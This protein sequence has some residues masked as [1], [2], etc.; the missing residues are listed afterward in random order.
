MKK[1]EISLIKERFNSLKKGEVVD[2]TQLTPDCSLRRYFR[3]RHS[4][5]AS[6]GSPDG[7]DT[8]DTDGLK[9]MCS[10]EATVIAVLYDSVVGAE[11][12]G[13]L[14]IRSDDAFVNV[15]E[16]FRANGLNVPEILAEFRDDSLYFIEDFGDTI[17][18][19][20]LLQQGSSPRSIAK[21]DGGE[22]TAE[23]CLSDSEVYQL[24]CRAIDQ[25]VTLQSIAP[26]G[27]CVAFD[28]LFTAE[29]YC[30]EMQ[31]VIDYSLA[32]IEVSQS[33]V[34]QMKEGFLKL[35]KRLVRHPIVLT[36]RDY[37]PWNLLVLNGKKVGIIDFQDALQGSV[38]YDVV[39]LLNDRSADVL[40]GR[41]R[42]YRLWNY[43]KTA[44]DFDRNGFAEL[45]YAESL[46]QR[47][48]KVVGLFHKIA[49]LRGLKQYLGWVPGTLYRIGRTLAFLG[50]DGI[51]KGE[52]DSSVPL[53]YRALRYELSLHFPEVVEG[54][55]DPLFAI[56][57]VKE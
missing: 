50:N 1:K 41:E 9:V 44:L 48:L 32:D 10:G 8:E 6:D 35:A 51:Y 28:R 43:A 19:D 53:A 49:K 4:F 31:Q 11:T 52:T 26:D 42:Y 30:A 20:V 40:L 29:Q 24:F 33:S 22:V 46:L 37:H 5:T 16:C 38:Y 17:L 13:C 54:I 7:E 12:S 39:G 18:G 36:H 56:E 45:F 3:I 57:A 14:P 15:A 27:K 34:R 55:K 47:D 21:T 25:L 23:E 2:I